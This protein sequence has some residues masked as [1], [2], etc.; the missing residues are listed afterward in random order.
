MKFLV[1]FL[2]NL[3]VLVPVSSFA[4]GRGPG[5]VAPQKRSST[6]GVSQQKA[7]MVSYGK[8]PLYFIKNNGQVDPTVR[9]YERGAGHATFFTDDSILMV[10]AR[11]LK[12]SGGK[13][14]VKSERHVSDSLALHFIGAG[15]A[16]RIMASRVM[17]GRVN[18]F[19][20]NDHKKWRTGIPSFGAVTYRDVYKSI[21]IKFYGN[22]RSL[23]H[24][25]IVRPGGDL[26]EVKFAYKGVK[27]LKVTEDGGLE[28]ILK[29]GKITQKKPPHLS[30]D[31]R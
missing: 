15:K 2:L 24:D 9:F 30:G 22:N 25:V 13:D 6:L 31:R 21:D 11:P 28:V 23:E 14:S 26:S 7:T 1:F 20:G 29:N 18:Y 17:A 8:L 19:K 10:L 5:P 12:T 27:G 16:P 3:F 4:A